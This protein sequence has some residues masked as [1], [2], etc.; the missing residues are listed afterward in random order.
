MENTENVE[1]KKYT[2]YIKYITL[3]KTNWK[4]GFVWQRL[5]KQLN[6]KMYRP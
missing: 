1:Y 3:K 2:K 5:E 4:R 6:A